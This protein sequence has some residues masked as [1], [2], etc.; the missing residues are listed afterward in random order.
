[1]MHY[2]PKDRPDTDYELES[3]VSDGETIGVYYD[4]DDDDGYYDDDG[5][6]YED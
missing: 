4:E 1:M 6:E 3:Y 2:G 5:D